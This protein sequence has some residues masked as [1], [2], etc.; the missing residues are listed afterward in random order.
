[1][2]V[3]FAFAQ[4][5]DVWPFNIVYADKAEADAN[6]EAYRFNCVQR[7][8]TTAV[9]KVLMLIIFPGAHQNTLEQVPHILLSWAIS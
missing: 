2:S 4:E 7:E 9:K 8:S 5:C 1:M 3:G 6:K